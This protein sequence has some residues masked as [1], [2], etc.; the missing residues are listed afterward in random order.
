MTAKPL[1]MK[2]NLS[3]FFPPPQ[4]NNLKHFQKNVL[5]CTLSLEGALKGCQD[6]GLYLNINNRNKFA[7]PLF[8]FLLKHSLTKS[9]LTCTHL[10]G[11]L[12]GITIVHLVSLYMVSFTKKGVSYACLKIYSKKRK[13]KKTQS[14]YIP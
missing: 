7:T 9:I 1:A 6:D 10:S 13:K 8:F 11:I 4:S 14:I 2:T 12:K 5:N 3:L